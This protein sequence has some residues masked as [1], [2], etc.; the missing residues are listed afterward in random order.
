MEITG[1]DASAFAERVMY[2]CLARGL[3]FKL[4]MGSI[5][6]LT[7]ALTI[8]EEELDRAIEILSEAVEQAA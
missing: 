6:T 1:P 5:V 3:N 4:T 7:P 2:D 8:A